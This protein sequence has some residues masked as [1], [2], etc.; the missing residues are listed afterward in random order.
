MV[1]SIVAI[2]GDITAAQDD[3]RNLPQVSA[4]RT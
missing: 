2:G 3:A 1:S 4:E